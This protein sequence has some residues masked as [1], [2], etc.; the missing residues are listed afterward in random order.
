MRPGCSLKQANAGTTLNLSTNESKTQSKQWEVEV[1]YTSQISI[2]DARGSSP[3]AP[4]SL[5][6]SPQYASQL[7][8]LAGFPH[9]WEVI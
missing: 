5:I 6:S 3:A 1:S 8:T 2:L 9:T 4:P 7:E